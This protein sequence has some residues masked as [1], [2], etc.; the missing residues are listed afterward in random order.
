[1]WQFLIEA[2]TL[3]GMGG[4]IGLL[5]GWLVTLVIRL[6][7]PSYVPL[8]APV[9]GPGLKCWHWSGLWSLAGLEGLESRSYRRACVT[10]RQLPFHKSFDSYDCQ[11]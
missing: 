1:M 2:M 10:N 5:I 8:W 7:V 11:T 9:V 6:I 3:T 4:V